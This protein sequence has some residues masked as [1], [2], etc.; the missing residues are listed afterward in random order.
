MWEQKS[1]HARLPATPAT[2]SPMAHC[3][4]SNGYY[5]LIRIIGPNY[6][7]TKSAFPFNLKINKIKTLGFPPNNIFPNW[8]LPNSILP[9]NCLPK[10]ILTV[11]SMVEAMGTF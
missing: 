2:W 4:F 5:R 7:N 3:I 1:N 6:I 11:N 8:C 9:K 10:N